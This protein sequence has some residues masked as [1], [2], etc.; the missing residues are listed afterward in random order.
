MLSVL[1]GSDIMD[2]IRRSPEKY[3]LQKV[4]KNRHRIVKVIKEYENEKDAAKDLARLLTGETS[5]NELM[6]EN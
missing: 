6:H 4:G 1:E 5:E 2:I 3:G